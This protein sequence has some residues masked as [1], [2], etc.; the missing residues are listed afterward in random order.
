MVWSKDVRLDVDESPV[1][2][3]SLC[4]CIPLVAQDTL[5]NLF[6][7]GWAMHAVGQLARAVVQKANPTL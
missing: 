4:L 3:D 1:P 2:H 6:A 7:I 5:L